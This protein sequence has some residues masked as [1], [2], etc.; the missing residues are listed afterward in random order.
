MRVVQRGSPAEQLKNSEE[1]IVKRICLFLVFVASV[2]LWAEQKYSATCMVL[3]VDRGHQSFIASCQAIPGFMD[4]MSMPFEVHDSKELDG[5][6]PGTLVEFTLVVD[7]KSAY[8]EHL[9]IRHYETVEQD[10][11]AARQLK[12]LSR[13]TGL[14]KAAPPALEVGRVVP[15]FTLMDQIHQRISLSQFAGKVV[16]LNFIYTSCALPK[17]CFRSSN[18]FGVL[19]RRFKSYLGR[20]LILLTVTFDPQ[21]DSPEVLAHYSQTWKADPKVWHFLTGP[22]PDVRRVTDVFGMEFFPDEGLMDHSLH[23]AIIGRDGKLIANIEGN[24][25]TAE[26]LADLVETVLRDT[27]VQHV[28]NH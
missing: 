15:D 20:D 4:A 27:S 2:R 9:Q 5:L 28:A 22:V 7:T 26:Q 11:W 24:R 16:A 14:S 8:A 23:T 17:Y 1:T 19:Q 3:S 25:F 18:N 6:V 12:L 13:I 10:P 21:H